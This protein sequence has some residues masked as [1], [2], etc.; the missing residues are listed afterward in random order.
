MGLLNKVGVEFDPGW[1]G[2]HQGQMADYASGGGAFTT[3]LF[4]FFG[5]P[6]TVGFTAGRFAAELE[7]AGKG[8]ATA[9]VR[10]A[11]R[12]IFGADIDR[13]V[14]K[15]DETAWR[16]N[17]HTLG[18]YSYARPGRADARE[19]LA[20][21]ID[22]KLFFAGEATMRDAYATVHGAWRSGQEVAE[23]VAAALR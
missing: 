11:L 23:K 12:D 15:T 4:G 20:T 18:S 10:Q 2:A 19:A 8:A 17:P 21:P 22:D 13:Y 7:A 16:T 1:A 9:H 3:I 14:R 6:L 5:T